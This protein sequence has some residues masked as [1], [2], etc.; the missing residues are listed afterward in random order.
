MIDTHEGERWCRTSMPKTY[1][2]DRQC[3]P[4]IVDRPGDLGF[5]PSSGSQLLYFRMEYMEKTENI[6]K[7]N[8]DRKDV[9]LEGS[10]RD[11]WSQ[12]VMLSCTTLL[13]SS[14]ENGNHSK[15]L[16]CRNAPRIVQGTGQKH[17]ER[18]SV[19][20]SQGSL[21]LRSFRLVRVG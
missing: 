15:V 10:F 11:E 9:T 17:Q 6:G 12:Y 19:V 7:N 20:Y 3:L 2:V 8:Y 21:W 16:R 14:M 13:S 1:I 5:T 4:Y 18:L